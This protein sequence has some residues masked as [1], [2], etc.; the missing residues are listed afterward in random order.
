[1]TGCAPKQAEPAYGLYFNAHTPPNLVP[2]PKGI[3]AVFELLS[4]SGR[5]SSMPDARQF[6]DH[7][8]VQKLA[9]R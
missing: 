8:Y 7:R 3:T 6:I 2:D 4:E 5:I 9:E 1:C